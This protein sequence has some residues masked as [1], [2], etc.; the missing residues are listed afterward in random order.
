MHTLCQRYL[1]LKVHDCVYIMRSR[2]VLEYNWISGV[3]S[4]SYRNNIIS[5]CIIMHTDIN[6]LSERILLLHSRICVHA[7][8]G[9]D[10]Y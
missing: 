1:L 9:W 3:H 5:W 4:L 2:N 7:M 8:L 10:I 6:K